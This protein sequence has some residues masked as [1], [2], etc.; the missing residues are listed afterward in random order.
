MYK[1]RHIIFAF[2]FMRNKD[3]KL[4]YLFKR[5]D[6]VMLASATKFI[7][8]TFRCGYDGKVYQIL[9]R[10]VELADYILDYPE[11]RQLAR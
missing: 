4:R 10:K 5:A 6:A 1:E 2:K 8:P 11:F 7:L 3:R 9:D